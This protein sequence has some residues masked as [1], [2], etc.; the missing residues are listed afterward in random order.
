MIAQAAFDEERAAVRLGARLRVAREEAGVSL[1]ELAR[2]LGLRDH[3]V[4]IKY[5]R[6]VTPPRSVRLQAI[7]QILGCSAAALL[8]ATD[9]AAPIINAVDHADAGQ[10]AQLSFVLET[11]TSAPPAPPSDA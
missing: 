6:G 1:R 4:L 3:T 9:E 10:I 11:L 8:A 5:E 7:A 2:Q